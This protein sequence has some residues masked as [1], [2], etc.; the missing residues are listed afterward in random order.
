VF[1]CCCVVPKY[2]GVVIIMPLCLQILHPAFVVVLFIVL[3]MQTLTIF[4]F[5]AHFSNVRAVFL[6]QQSLAAGPTNFTKIIIIKEITYRNT[7]LKPNIA[8]ELLTFMREIGRS[9]HVS[10]SEKRILNGCFF[11]GFLVPRWKPHSFLTYTVDGGEW[12]ASRPVHFTSRERVAIPIAPEPVWMMCRR[13]GILRPQGI[14][15]VYT[16]SGNK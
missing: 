5:F 1:V 3:C 16:W 13:E 9:W 6:W 12:S 4:C 14:R 7:V 15:E 10:H 2:V 8:I 11:G